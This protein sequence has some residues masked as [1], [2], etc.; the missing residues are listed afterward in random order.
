MLGAQNLEIQLQGMDGK[1]FFSNLP[2]EKNGPDGEL[3]IGVNLGVD[4][5]LPGPK[6]QN[7]NQIQR[8]LRPIISDLLPLWKVGVQLPMELCPQGW[9]VY[10]ILMAVVCDKL[11]AHK[12]E[13][14]A[15]HFHMHFFDLMHNLFLGLVKT[16]FY[17]IWVQSKILHANH[18]LN[19]FHD[20]LADLRGSLTADQ[21]LLLVTVYGPIIHVTQ[22]KQLETQKKTAANHKSEQKRALEEAKKKG[23]ATFD[24]EKA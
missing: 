17:D 11:A 6:E 5:I 16:H 12:I 8:F 18:E 20:M 24:A 21:W 19:I 10:V 13:G 3:R 7:P 9:L 2:H 4:C 1:I 23:K 22:I 14:F 15:S